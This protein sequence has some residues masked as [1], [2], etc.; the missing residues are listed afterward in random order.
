MRIG[1]I[2]VLGKAKSIK[3]VLLTSISD[4]SQTVNGWLETINAEIIDIKFSVNE[5]VDAEGNVTPYQKALI[6]YKEENESNA[7]IRGFND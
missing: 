1:G 5:I 2:D 7:R 4:V 6:I 3:T